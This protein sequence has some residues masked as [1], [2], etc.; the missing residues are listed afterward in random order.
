[1][2]ATLNAGGGGKMGSILL[3]LVELK[4]NV[5]EMLVVIQCMLF[6]ILENF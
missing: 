2:F 5:L 6:Y 1:M 3:E 4:L